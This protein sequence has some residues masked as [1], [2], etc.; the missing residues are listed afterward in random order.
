MPWPPLLADATQAELRS[1]VLVLVLA[2]SAAAAVLSRLHSRLVLP[3]VVLEIVLGI[4]I[5]PQVLSIA[6]LNE[7]RCSGDRRAG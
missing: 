5:G 4:L 1:I 7:G 2:A 3:A 6:H